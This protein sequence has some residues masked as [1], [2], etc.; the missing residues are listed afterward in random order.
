[1]YGQDAVQRGLPK[2]EKATKAKLF[3]FWKEFVCRRRTDLALTFLVSRGSVGLHDRVRLARR[4]VL[5]ARHGV[6]WIFHFVAVDVV[7]RRDRKGL[8]AVLELMP[9]TVRDF[10]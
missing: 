2:E 1:M 6:Q 7:R 9:A 10:I 8:A 5:A 3:L 4:D